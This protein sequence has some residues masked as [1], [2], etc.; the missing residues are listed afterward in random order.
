MLEGRPTELPRLR[1]FVPEDAFL[2]HE[3]YHD[4]YYKVMFRHNTM[5]ATWTDFV[6]YPQ[7]SNATV[8]MITIGNGDMTKTV[9]SCLAYDVLPKSGVCGYGILIDKNY[10]KQKLCSDVTSVMLNYIFSRMGLR[11]VYIEIVEEY[12]PFLVDLA[13]RFGFRK[14]GLF[15]KSAYLDNKLVDEVRMACFAEGFKPIT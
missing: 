1:C 3:W 11:K 2:I 6:T 15:R 13:K 8:K 5:R 4:D 7:W 10:N 9:G 12:H 14:E